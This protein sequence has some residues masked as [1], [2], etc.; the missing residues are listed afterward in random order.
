[1]FKGCTQPIFDVGQQL[2][3]VK[4]ALDLLQIR[5]P[6]SLNADGDASEILG[7]IADAIGDS[8]SRNTVRMSMD[9]GK[10]SNPTART[11]A[12]MRAML[13]GSTRRRF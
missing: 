9:G 2:E 1:M 13:P 11:V 8:V 7:A 6:E 5:L 4:R 12:N 10:G 3:R